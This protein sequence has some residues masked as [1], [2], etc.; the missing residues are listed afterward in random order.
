M[1]NGI[2]KRS[3]TYAYARA[4][5]VMS[6]QS[7]TGFEWSVKLIGTHFYV[8]IASKLQP[9]ILICHYDPEAILYHSPGISPRH[10]ISPDIRRGSTTIHSCLGTPQSGDVVRFKFQPDAKKLIIY[11]VRKR[12]SSSTNL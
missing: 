3:G 7:E 9:R 4:T 12:D 2:F 6:T 8:G 5:T 11:W 10:R 1:T